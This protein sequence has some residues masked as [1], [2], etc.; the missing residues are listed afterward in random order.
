[1]GK[2]TRT[3]ETKA[4]RFFF[5]FFLIYIL[6]DKQIIPLLTVTLCSKEGNIIISYGNCVLHT[7]AASLGVTVS[8][9]L[10]LFISDFQAETCLKGKIM[11]T[12]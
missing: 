2:Q 1:M 4:T 7:A 10:S 11:Y 3:T 8:N 9:V 12:K 6:G 5:F